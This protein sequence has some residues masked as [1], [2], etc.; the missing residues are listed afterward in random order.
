MKRTIGFYF[1]MLF[2][3]MFITTPLFSATEDDLVGTWSMYHSAKLKVS[4]IGTTT[5]QNNSTVTLNGD[6][7]FTMV[8]NDPPDT[9][10]YTGN[11]Q[12]IKKGKKV[13]ISF[14]Q[15]GRDELIRLLEDWMTEVASGY[16]VPISDINISLAKL[17]ISQPSIPKK[18]NIPKTTT[19]KATGLVSA[20]LDGMFITRKFSYDSKVSFI[21]RQ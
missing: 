19:I 20:Y 13:L 4:R 6:G 15:G 18:T 1:A 16:G 3:V 5:S 10:T 21:C 11:W 8:E 17:T 2:F 9:Y 12:L 7:T 14:D